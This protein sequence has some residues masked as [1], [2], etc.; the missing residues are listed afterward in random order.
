[1]KYLKL[2][3]V[4]LVIMAINSCS[5]KKNTGTSKEDA[6]GSGKAEIFFNTLEHDFGTVTEGEKVA[7]VFKY[8]NRGTADLVILEATTSCGCTIPRFNDE[9]VAPGEGGTI[10][11]VFDT[12]NRSGVQYKSIELKSNA[13]ERVA[14]LRITADI[15]TNN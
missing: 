10:E 11:V 1:M 15:I 6:A 13:T 4:F 14:V 9:P 7:C 5:G 2:I 12:S 3:P 8:E